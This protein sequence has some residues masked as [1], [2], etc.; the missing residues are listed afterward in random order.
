MS[1]LC[2]GNGGTTLGR[3]SGSRDGCAWDGCCGGALGQAGGK[4]AYCQSHCPSV[5][6]T[7]LSWPGDPEPWLPHQPSR[8]T[9]AQ[10]GW[11]RLPT[12]PLLH[13]QEQGQGCHGKQSTHGN[14]ACRLLHPWDS[15][16]YRS[17][18]HSHTQHHRRDCPPCAEDAGWH[19]ALPRPL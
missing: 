10:R 18:L 9:V 16:M 11:V 7:K 17:L 13:W 12:A 1:W 2:P 6:G 8:V 15:P 5:M 14:P 4:R 19:R 3:Q